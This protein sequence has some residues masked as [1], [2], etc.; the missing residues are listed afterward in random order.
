MTSASRLFPPQCQTLDKGHGRIEMREIWTSTELNGYI[1]FPHV[2]QV[3]RVKR[4]TTDLN[5]DVVRGRKGIEEIS[6]G[7]TSMNEQRASAK[8]LLRYNRGHWV[9]ENKLHHVRDVTF[10]EDRSQVRKGNRPHAMATFRNLAISLL[11]LA[12]AN[13]IAEATR[14]LGR[15][16]ERPLCFLGFNVAM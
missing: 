6:L 1:D 8:E 4:T 10:D 11:R 5:G 2:G 3:F 7:V 16:F 13:N 14:Y 9:I 15:Q 12:G